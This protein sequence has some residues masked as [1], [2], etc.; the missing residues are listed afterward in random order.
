MLRATVSVGTSQT[1]LRR[2]T[3]RGRS[4]RRCTRSALRFI[5]IPCLYRRLST[6]RSSHLRDTMSRQASP[7]GRVGAPSL[8]FTS[9][10]TN[11]S[12]ALRCA[13]TMILSTWLLGHHPRMAPSPD[14]F[15]F[16]LLDFRRLHLRRFR[17]LR[18]Y[19]PSPPPTFPHFSSNIASSH[20]ICLP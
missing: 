9:P 6:L 1:R 5:Q 18:F 17:T 7:S 19:I 14:G 8:R 12:S 3:G 11:P 16:A 4:T 15:A 13:G 2:H 20:F 10:P